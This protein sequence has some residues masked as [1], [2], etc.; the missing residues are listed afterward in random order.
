MLGKRV[1]FSLEFSIGLDFILKLERTLFLFEDVPLL[2]KYIC[3][4]DLMEQ[5]FLF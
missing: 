5:S 3:I 4:W 2:N 1:L